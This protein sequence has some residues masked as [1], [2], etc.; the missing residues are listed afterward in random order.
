MRHRHVHKLR[1]IGAMLLRNIG[2][3]RCLR[4]HLGSSHHNYM[5]HHHHHHEEHDLGGSLAEPVVRI[6]D[7]I[8]HGLKPRRYEPLK[9]KN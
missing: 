6:A 9:F 3:G 8:G 1:S 2:G 4:Q 7:R 5:H